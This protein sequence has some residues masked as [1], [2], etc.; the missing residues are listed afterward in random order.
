MPAPGMGESPIRPGSLPLMPPVETATTNRPSESRATAPTV[1]A[2]GSRCWRLRLLMKTDGSVISIPWSRAKREAPDPDSSTWRPSCITEAARSL[3]W[4]TSFKQA[5]PPARSAAP[6]MTPASSSTSPSALRHAPMP[7]LRRG[8]SSIWRTAATAAARAPSPIRAQPS[9]SARSTA[10]WRNGRSAA[11]TGPAPPWTMSAGGARASVQAG[12][13]TRRSRPR[14]SCS[15]R[16]G[17]N[18]TRRPALVRSIDRLSPNRRSGF[19]RL[20]VMRLSVPRSTWVSLDSIPP[21]LLIRW[22]MLRHS[23]LNCGK[24]FVKA[25]L[26]PSPLQLIARPHVDERRVFRQPGVHLADP[27]EHLLGDPPVVGVALRRG[28]QLAEVIEL[29]QV[30]AEEPPHAKRKRNDV[31]CEGG[32]EV[33]LEARVGIGG[34]L[35]GRYESLLHPEL[36][37]PGRHV[38][39]NAGAEQLSV[40][41]E[42]AVAVQVAVGGEVGDDLERVLRVLERPRRSLAAV[43]AI[44]QYGVQHLARVALQILPALIR[45]RKQRRGDHLSFGIDVML[46]EAD[47]RPR[48]PRPGSR[49]QPGRGLAH[50]HEPFGA[51][52]AIAL[53]ER[54]FDERRDDE[55]ELPVKI[56]G[57]C[58]AFGELVGGELGDEVF[59]SPSIAEQAEV[60]QGPRR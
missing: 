37:Q 42:H 26:R 41:G 51:R 16:S 22:T 32:S 15:R 13:K 47:R 14:R 33:A 23:T 44:R 60:R 50:S 46:D 20:A 19:T 17:T 58:S 6:S 59:E 5:T 36:R 38:I 9:S 52:R 57:Q 3:G 29:A 4:R 21:S 54:P 45:I 24:L 43:G 40:L 55:R 7:A 35:D 12:E 27:P 31:L 2:P 48:F 25:A 53:V 39:P 11:G 1:S 28:P 18:S 8:S 34:P 56:A 10:A 30:D 49:R